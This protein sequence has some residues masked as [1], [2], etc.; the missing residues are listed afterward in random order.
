MLVGCFA[1]ASMLA[2]LAEFDNLPCFL[3]ALLALVHA[4]IA[5]QNS[6]GQTIACNPADTVVCC[7]SQQH[8]HCQGDDIERWY[9]PENNG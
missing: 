5:V 6:F 8:S 9:K 7:I 2:T 1:S 3:L 4:H